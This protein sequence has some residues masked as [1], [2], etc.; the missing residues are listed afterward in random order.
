MK[1]NLLSHSES[2]LLHQLR[3]STGLSQKAFAQ[4]IG[5]SPQ[6]IAAYESG[7]CPCDVH[8]LFKILD[9]FGFT[10]VLETKP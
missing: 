8:T 10:M 3:R 2:E 7:L 6:T 1:I 5:L 9:E 4:R